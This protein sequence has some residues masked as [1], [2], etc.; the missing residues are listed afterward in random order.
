[1]ADRKNKFGFEPIEAPAAK[2]RTRSPGPM[3]TAV[4]EAAEDLRQSTDAK[5]E[6][7]RRNSE[8]A[9]VLRAAREDG[10]LIERVALDAVL[11]DALPRDRLDL[12][13]VAVSEA[14][15]ELKA[16]ILA[17]G[18]KEPIEVW[19][20]G[21]GA[22]QLKKGWRR[23]TALRQ[24]RDETGEA[25]F[26]TVLA[27]ISEADDT[28]LDRYVDMVEENVIREDLTFAEMAA[29]V[30]EAAA[31]PAVDETNPGA[32]VSRLYGSLHKTKRSYIRSFVFL[33]SALGDDLKFPKDLPRNLG[34]SVSRRLQDDG[35]PDILRERLRLAQSGEIQRVVLEAFLE[36]AEG[37]GRVAERPLKRDSK[38]TFRVNDV[39]VVARRGECRIV[40]DRDF[41][42]VPR[43]QLEEALL[44][45]SE[46]ISD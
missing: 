27:R 28:R 4:R 44:R 9:K 46:A 21:A 36:A 13:D 39:K 43:D 30:L 32:L 17:R 37:K 8:D 25:A 16:S 18:Q 3:G 20:D 26:D 19:R 14:M 42:E 45:F 6:Q 29:V 35:V 24:L 40:M 5:V 22:L 12:S 15:D 31:D 41:T 10:R 38:V 33:L 34:V 1:M 2:E 11:T 23:L 7:R